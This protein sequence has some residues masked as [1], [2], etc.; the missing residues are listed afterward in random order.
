MAVDVGKY[1]LATTLGTKWPNL[2]M[3]R[4]V[5][6]IRKGAKQRIQARIIRNKEYKQRFIDFDNFWNKKGWYLMVVSSLPIV[7][8]LSIKS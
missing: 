6:G 1:Q 5:E 7:C 2:F 4:S 3:K 8:T